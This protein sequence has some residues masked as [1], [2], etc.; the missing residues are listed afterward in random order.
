MAD[1]AQHQSSGGGGHGGESGPSPIHVI[2][3]LVLN[4]ARSQGSRFLL[5]SIAVEVADA[6][7]SELVSEREFEIR[8]ALILVLGAKSTEELT[9]I[10]KRPAIVE[11]IHDAIVEIM[12]PDVVRHVFIP[13][14]VIQ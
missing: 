13:Q 14:F 11:E 3:N 4:P 7:L 12:G 2:D 8:A 6:E 5:V 10:E 9:D 1:R